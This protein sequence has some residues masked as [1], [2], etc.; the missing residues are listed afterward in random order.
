MVG[1]NFFHSQIDVVITK[2]LRPQW[3]Q[4]SLG[5]TSSW[6]WFTFFYFSEVE[7]FRTF[8][9]HSHRAWVGCY[10]SNSFTFLC[11]CPFPFTFPCPLSHHI[12]SLMLSIWR[13]RYVECTSSAIQ[14]LLLFKKLYPNHR[15][16]EVD[17]FIEKET[18]YVE[19]VQDRMD[20]GMHL[21]R[22]W[23][24]SWGD[25]NGWWFWVWSKNSHVKQY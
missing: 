22:F 13:I 2:F 3:M 7:S 8:H 18:G 14:T 12:H 1:G 19:D 17:N 10:I 16:K 21:F 23:L 4:L 5:L 24:L 25:G 6:F 15:R 11:P 9:Q 20:L